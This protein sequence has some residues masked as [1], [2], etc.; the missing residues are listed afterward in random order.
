[1]ST[2]RLRGD[3]L[4]RIV[5]RAVHRNALLSGAS[6]QQARARAREASSHS[7]R[8]GFV[9]SALAAGVPSEDI[10]EYIGWKN[11]SLVF[12]YARQSEPLRANPARLVLGL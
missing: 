12:Y 7:L 10:A 2:K 4:S 3:S 5:R 1:V 6:E 9:V 11:P 8:V